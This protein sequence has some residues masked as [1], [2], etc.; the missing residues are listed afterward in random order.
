[1]AESFPSRKTRDLRTNRKTG[2]ITMKRFTML[3][4]CLLALASFMA[5][6]A[7]AQSSGAHYQ[8]GSVSATIQ[9]NG[10]LVVSWVEAGLGNTNVNYSLTANVNA[11]YF[12]R[13]KSGNIPDANNKHTVNA[14]PS[15]NGSFEPKNG[16]VTASLTLVAPPAPSS[17]PPTCGGGQ[18]LDL[19]SITWSNVVLTDVDYNDVFSFGS[20][21]FSLTF[22]PAP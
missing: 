1:M 4:I 18:T 15:T 13:T 17:E 3:T 9:S 12:C 8:H 5:M 6:P 11:T 21:T 7:W 14:T 16:K 22:F 20:G 10:N 2:G 19:Q